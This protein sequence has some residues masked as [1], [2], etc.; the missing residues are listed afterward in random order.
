M[1]GNSSGCPFMAHSVRVI[2]I[3]RTPSDPPEYNALPTP[4][5]TRV[6][7]DL[8]DEIGV[9]LPVPDPVHEPLAPL[10]EKGRGVESV[11]L[12]ALLSLRGWAAAIFAST[13]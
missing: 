6:L 13:Y 10:A 12:A 3:V 9:V 7:R 4:A 11:S 2:D 8:R 5:G 1:F